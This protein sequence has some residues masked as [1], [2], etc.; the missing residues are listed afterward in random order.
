[1]TTQRTTIIAGLLLLVAGVLRAELPPDA[2]SAMEKGVLAAQQQDYALAAKYFAEARELAPEAPELLY[3]LGLAE[4]KIPGRELRAIAWFGAYLAA[5]PA[6]PNA[7]A[8]R[9]QMDALDVTNQVNITRFIKTTTDAANL[10]PNPDRQREDLIMPSLYRGGSLHYAV[11]LLAKNG[12]S[13]EALKVA[14]GIGDAG[15][16]SRAQGVVGLILAKSGDKAGARKCFSLAVRTG[17]NTGSSNWALAVNQAWAGEIEAALMT[18]ESVTDDAWASGYVKCEIAKAMIEKGD[19]PAANQLLAEVERIAYYMKNEIGDDTHKS[20]TYKSLGEVY[21][22]AGDLAAAHKAA[23]Q[24]KVDWYKK[25]VLTEIS[26]AQAAKQKYDWKSQ[27]KSGDFAG[28]LQAVDKLGQEKWTAVSAVAKMQAGSGDFAGALNTVAT[29]P[30]NWGK[31]HARWVVIEVQIQRQSPSAPQDWI[32]LNT[33]VLSGPIF[34]EFSSTLATL[35]KGSAKETFDAL[36][37]TASEVLL[38][39]AAV[40]RMMKMQRTKQ[41]KS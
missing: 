20:D 37:D 9:K 4:S 33:E 24:I 3:N 25:S 15:M 11:I 22:Q 19:I 23:D 7:K 14:E 12:N 21:V 2:Q 13:A 35:P 18:A 36:Y 41:I 1:M 34:T 26:N 5:N 39:R 8:V 28:A 38:M 29:I 27:A 32:A 40:T 10:V 30:N 16:R 17:K 6:A 31:D